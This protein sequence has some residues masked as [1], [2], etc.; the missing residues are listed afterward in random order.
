MKI[1]VI[2][3]EHET[4][5]RERYF[6]IMA[7]VKSRGWEVVHL[8]SGNVSAL[9]RLTTPFM[10]NKNQL[11]VIDDLDKIPATELKW[12]RKNE[13]RLEAN[14]LIWHKK[15]LGKKLINELPKNTSFELFKL[16]KLIFSFLDEIKPGS[17]R[18]ALKK[19][20]TIKKTE[21][22]EFVLALIANL[23]RDMMAVK[24]GGKLPY[25]AWR[26]KKIKTQAGYFS[27]DSL[28]KFIN[29]LALIDVEAKTGGV[30]L[31][32][33]LDLILLKHLE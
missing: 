26:I 12:L 20:Q 17:S 23:L 9:D 3:G 10:F 30:G 27:K 5:S 13:N 14:L 19:L 16:P 25:P 7:T 6:K 1:T 24:A 33:S 4:G 8:N 31:E 2:H 18:N 22:L 28:K 21:P 15:E 29:D 11:Y 32:T